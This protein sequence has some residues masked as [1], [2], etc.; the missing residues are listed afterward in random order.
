MPWITVKSAVKLQWEIGHSEYLQFLQW[1]GLQ[2]VCEFL[3]G[4]IYMGHPV[5]AALKT[6]PN[7]FLA[8]MEIDIYLFSYYH[9][10]FNISCTFVQKNV[11][12]DPFFRTV[13]F[14]PNPYFILICPLT[15]FL[16]SKFTST[17]EFS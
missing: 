3:C 5:E 17:L 7:F 13:N 6:K 2:C 16:L 4:L 12:L 10:C 15:N 1:K 14:I 8:I 9:F 11:Q